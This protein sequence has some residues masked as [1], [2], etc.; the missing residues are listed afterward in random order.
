MFLN[1][2]TGL[3]SH[4]EKVTATSEKK[5]AL[6]AGFE[7]TRGDPIGFQVQ[8]LNHS[9]KAA[10]LA[11]IWGNISNKTGIYEPNGT[12]TTH[13]VRLHPS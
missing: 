10:C 3:L 1:F 7:P 9:A 11:G 13:V 5:S 6:P 8:R 12:L 2:W 4:K